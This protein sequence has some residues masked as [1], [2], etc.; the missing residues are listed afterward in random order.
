MEK[1]G[2]ILLFILNVLLN[3]F[4]IVIALILIFWLFFGVTP[5]TSVQKTA[6]WLQHK[7]DSLIGY[8]PPESVELIS[9][10]QKRRAYRNMY[11][12]T[13]DDIEKNK[14]GYTSQPHKYEYKKN[15]L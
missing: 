8:S 11:V 10:K 1:L 5:E 2:H 13:E 3:T 4:L 14:P 7:W 9:E 12:Q 15:E 6:N